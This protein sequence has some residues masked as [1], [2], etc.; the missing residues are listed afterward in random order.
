MYVIQRTS[1]G[2]YY[3][4][5]LLGDKDRTGQDLSRYFYDIFTH[6]T[7]FNYL[8]KDRTQLHKG[9]S[10]LQVPFDPKRDGGCFH[11]VRYVEY[12]PRP[13]MPAAL[14]L[15]GSKGLMMRGNP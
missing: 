6:A 4:G 3:N 9:E 8:Q 10:W 13:T 2:L 5:V 14:R 12:V 11:K 15:P 7:R 1:D